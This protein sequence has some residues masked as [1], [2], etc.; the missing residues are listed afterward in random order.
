[1]GPGSFI[2]GLGCLADAIGSND[3]HEPLRVSL[4]MHF[5]S[6][7]WAGAHPAITEALAR[8]SDGFAPAYGASELDSA[9]DARFRA[10]FGEQAKA[11]FVATGTA[12]NS[13]ALSAVNRPG[14]VA[15]CHSHAHVTEDECGA[16]EFFTGGGRLCPVEGADGKIDPQML[17]AAIARF[18]AEFVHSGQPMAVTITQ[19]SE[20]GTVYSLAEIRKI[21]GICRRHGLPLHMDGARFANAMVTLGCSAAEMTVDCGVGLL[22]FGGTKNGCWCAEALVVLDPSLGRD[23]PFLRKR[24]AQLFSKS[25]FIA[26]QFDAYF[27]DD[28][29]LQL[30]RHANSMAARLAQAIRASSQMRLAWEFQA[31]EVFVVMPQATADRLKREGAVFYPWPVP[32]HLAGQLTPGENLFRFVT[33]FATSDGEIDRFRTFLG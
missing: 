11:Y 8:N 19:A 7:N 31:N 4:A 24:G 17:E 32:P 23:L 26:A 5:G 15:F 29:W 1:M 3:S 22:S 21:A 9:V 25:R 12:A 30:A 20:A 33:S 27:R 28:L 6:D 18:P 13:L 2:L 14:G 16:P 10:L